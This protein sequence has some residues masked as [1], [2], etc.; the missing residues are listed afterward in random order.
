MNQQIQQFLLKLARRALE[1]YFE[2][3]KTI[4]LDESELSDPIL[5]EERGTFVTLHLHGQLRGC[6]GHIEPIQE[7]YKDIIDN[8]LSA[9]FEDPRFM[10]LTQNELGDIDIEI[11]VLTPPEKLA[12][13]S[14]ED[15]LIKL[16]PNIDGVIIEK[17]RYGATYL[18]QVWEDLPDKKDFLSSLCVKAGLPHDE[19]RDGRLKVSIYKA[20]VF[21]DKS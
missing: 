17:G 12:Y 9:A 11:S 1:H 14:T 15:L 2:Y 10:P 6:I 5:K 13:G 20:E 4:E 3:H 19:W 7:F 18:P 16:R 8:A 21:G